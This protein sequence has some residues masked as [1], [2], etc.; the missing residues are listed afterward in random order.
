M[1]NQEQLSYRAGMAS[2]STLRFTWLP[3]MGSLGKPALQPQ[4]F[5]ASPTRHPRYSFASISSRRRAMR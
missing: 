5:A 3:A 1:L 2:G 4:L